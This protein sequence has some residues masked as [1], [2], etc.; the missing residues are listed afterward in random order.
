MHEEIKRMGVIPIRF[1]FRRPKV[2]VIFAQHTK[3]VLLH[4]ISSPR[5]KCEAESLRVERSE[6]GVNRH[7]PFKVAEFMAAVLPTNFAR[8]SSVDCV[9]REIVDRERSG[10]HPGCERHQLAA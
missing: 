1:I 4:G 2:Q 10:S 8:Q 5:L 6:D 7:L 3:D 9:S